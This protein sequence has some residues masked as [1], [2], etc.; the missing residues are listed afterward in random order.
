MTNTSTLKKTQVEQDSFDKATIKVIYELQKLG[1]CKNISQIEEHLQLG[2]RKLQQALYGERHVSKTHRGK[3]LQFFTNNYNVNPRIFSNVT[4]PVF[5]DVPPTLEEQPEKYF[6]KNEGNMLNL[7]DFV[8][9]ERQQ[10]EIADMK[11]KVKDL[12]KELKYWRTLGQKFLD[13][14]A[15]PVKAK[16]KTD[17]KTDKSKSRTR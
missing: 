14:H 16:K 1:F 6:S 3:L 2:A 7:G 5:K 10:K 8:K 9:M 15:K 13:T 11:E 4:E 12:Q 17:T